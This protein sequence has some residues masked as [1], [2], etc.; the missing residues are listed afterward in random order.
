M[1]HGRQ[2]IVT[3]IRTVLGQLPGGP[4]HVF[5]AGAF[6][7]SLK[8]PLP[9]LAVQPVEEPVVVLDKDGGQE[10]TLRI[11]VMVA[12]ETETAREDLCVLVEQAMAQEAPEHEP[13]LEET[14]LAV[15][16]EGRTVY[17]AQLVFALTWY[18]RETDPETVERVQ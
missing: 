13:T 10:R 6:A 9:A 4:A 2:Q 7:L 15:D 18:S 5:Q 11:A 12:A 16:T 17:S 1:S 3:Q 8:A 14:E